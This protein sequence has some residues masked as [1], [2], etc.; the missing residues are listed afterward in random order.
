MATRNN[1]NENIAMAAP[2]APRFRNLLEAYSHSAAPVD[3][4]KVGFYWP[5]SN[6]P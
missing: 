2:D 4:P 6:D 3:G 1:S 5:D